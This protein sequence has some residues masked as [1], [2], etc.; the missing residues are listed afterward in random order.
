[1]APASAHVFRD[2]MNGSWHQHIW[3]FTPRRNGK[4]ERNNRIF[5]EEFLYACLHLAF[6]SRARSG[7]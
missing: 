4:V 1:M 3:P 6:E 7:P 2:G 5:T